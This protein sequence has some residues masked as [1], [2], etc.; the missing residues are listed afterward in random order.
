MELPPGEGAG[1][2]RQV[3]EGDQPVPAK[4]R[5]RMLRR[6]VISAGILGLWLA[7][8]VSLGLILPALALLV[9][10]VLAGVVAL[11]VAQLRSV[12]L[13]VPRVDVRA[14][15]AAVPSSPRVPRLPRLPRVP[16]E[17]VSG[18]TRRALAAV[19]PASR[20]LGTASAVE[21]RRL[22]RAATTA[23]QRAQPL[24]S[25]V[26]K[27]L[28]DLVDAALAP[29]R[30]RQRRSELTREAWALNT[31]GV[32]HRR[33]GRSGAAVDA[34]EKAVALFRQLADD[35]NEG[36]ALNNLGLAL[37]ATGDDTGA[38]DAF[39]RALA[40]LGR[41]GDRPAEGRVLANL[42]TLYRRLDRQETALVY[43]RQALTRMEA[44]S[45]ERERMAELLESV[46]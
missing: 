40:L 25:R 39:E 19:P 11:V 17:R 36:L 18:G 46:R 26:E 43:W 14:L 35:R 7:L 32:E 9:V 37:M 45:P 28:R 10:G 12:E 29:I 27:I 20:R 33:A 30:R 1:G 34:H 42:G 6:L 41:S 15:R 2:A 38:I 31:E 13:S 22:G 21:A 3:P 16:V 8:L 23:G 24:A 44:D 4:G 5:A